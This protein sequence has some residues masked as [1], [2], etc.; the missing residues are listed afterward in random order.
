VLNQIFAF[1]SS[2]IMSDLSPR[3]APGCLPSSIR[4]PPQ[5]Y[6]AAVHPHVDKGAELLTR[7]P[8]DAIR[9]HG[10]I[11]GGHEGRLV[12]SE[13]PCMSPGSM[14]F[15]WIQTRVVLATLTCIIHAQ[16]SGISLSVSINGSATNGSSANDRASN[17]LD[18]RELQMMDCIH[19]TPWL[20]LCVTTLTTFLRPAS[21]VRFCWMLLHD[22]QGGCGSRKRSVFHHSTEPM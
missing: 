16:L 6:R 5:A 19:E 10:H 20:V 13:D 17:C 14:H 15:P 11:E 22:L 18:V 3:I 2:P 12:V 8:P 1:S 21:H 7:V 4:D 9:V